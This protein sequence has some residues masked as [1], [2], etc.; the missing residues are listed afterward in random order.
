MTR[1]L[2]L[3]L[4]LTSPAMAQD[5]PWGGPEI[6]TNHAPCPTVTL[7]NHPFGNSG[8]HIV[9][10]QTPQGQI[11]LRHVVTVNGGPAY[12]TGCCAD[13]MEA[14]DWPQGMTPIPPAISVPEG[15]TGQIEF[16]CWEGM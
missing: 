10:V 5:H 1:A 15:E 6:E 9:Y 8:V 11:T 14:R 7:H 3:A 12:E 2:V 4:C 13:D 16:T